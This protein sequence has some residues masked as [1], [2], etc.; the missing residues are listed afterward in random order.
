MK[1]KLGDGRVVT[2]DDARFTSFDGLKPG[3]SMVLATG[4]GAQR[5]AHDAQEA[6]AF[7]VSQ[8]AYTEGQTFEKLYTPMQYEDLI[9]ISFEAGEWAESI[10]YEI[11]DYVG[12][13]KRSAGRGKSMN[14]VDV[15]YADKTFPV[16]SGDIGYD[17]TTDE[18]RKSAFLRRP[19]PNTRLAA[20]MDG[21]QRHMNDVALWGEDDLT[22]LF[23]NA[24]VPHASA[25]TG[26]W[27]NSTEAEILAD[28]NGLI[29]LIWTSTAY[30]DFP[31]DIVMSPAKFSYIAAKPRS[32][33]S[34]KTVLQYI[35]ANNI[36]KTQ[37]GIDIKFGPGYGLETG[38]A[39]ETHRMM[40]Y[41]KS[42]L[43]LQMHIPLPL[44]FL[45]PQLVGLG[46]DVP[47]EYKYSGVEFRYPKSARYMD[48][49]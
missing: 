35:Q 30:N 42:P 2:V 26:D 15:A 3:L 16:V 25:P 40:G 6:L 38:G 23:N 17:Y 19:L 32:S 10:R 11:Y 13:G 8:L 24:N 22:G 18:L 45:A 12:R 34:D 29:D 14:R 4:D 27:A 46:V 47:G 41:V 49:I 39:G 1:I 43:R 21:Y 44:R 33:T 20:A 7:L 9:P 28:I 37:R 5:S 48:G 36:A 31:T